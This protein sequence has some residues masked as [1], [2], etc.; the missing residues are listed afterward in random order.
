MI[1]GHKRLWLQGTSSN[2]KAREG[3]ATVDSSSP[4]RFL[5]YR[6]LLLYHSTTH[7]EAQV[8]HSARYAANGLHN[9]IQRRG[10]HVEVVD[11]L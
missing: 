9:L 4:A 8:Q 7:E 11:G 10:R 6:S 1:P 2:S 3:D 5:E